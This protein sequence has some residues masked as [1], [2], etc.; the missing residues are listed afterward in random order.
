MSVG[1]TRPSNNVMTISPAMVHHAPALAALRPC[2]RRDHGIGCLSQH[3]W[4]ISVAG[5]TAAPCPIQPSQHKLRELGNNIR[6][7][8]AGWADGMAGGSRLPRPRSR[9]NGGGGGAKGRDQSIGEP[10]LH[11]PVIARG[12]VRCAFT[13]IA[14]RSAVSIE[15]CR[16]LL[17]AIQSSGRVRTQDW[18]G[19]RRSCSARP[20][21]VVA[22]RSA[23]HRAS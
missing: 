22:V 17:A 1:V 8:I 21:R 7:A 19:P 16:V 2:F 13:A 18:R 23:D 15:C 6:G 14:I 10:L 5:A 20:M 3:H 4:K 11:G 9:T 12:A